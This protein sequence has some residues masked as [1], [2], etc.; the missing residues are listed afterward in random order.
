M[1]KQFFTSRHHRELVKNL[2]KNR[3][4]RS[5]LKEWHSAGAYHMLEDL[6]DA[7]NVMVNSENGTLFREFLDEYAGDSTISMNDIVRARR[8]LPESLLRV[9]KP[10]NKGS[11]VDF[12]KFASQ[13]V[14]WH[15]KDAPVDR[16]VDRAEW[17]TGFMSKHLD[18]RLDESRQLEFLEQLLDAIELFAKEEMTAP[19]SADS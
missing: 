10:I 13:L 12:R 18:G 5:L 7:V 14:A 16:I 11:I 9:M 4:F 6:I 2:E 3:F 17:E 1:Y 19:A 15:L 8:V